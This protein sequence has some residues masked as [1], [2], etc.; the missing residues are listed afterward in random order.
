MNLVFEWV[1]VEI[2]NTVVWMKAIMR[3]L[4][5]I[6]KATWSFIV[7]L[8]QSISLSINWLNEYNNVLFKESRIC[9][10]IEIIQLNTLSL[11]DGFLMT[12]RC[13]CVKEESDIEHS[14]HLLYYFICHVLRMILSHSRVKRMIVPF[15]SPLFF[16]CIHEIIQYIHYDMIHNPS[17]NPLPVCICSS[18]RGGFICD[19][20]LLVCSIH[21]SQIE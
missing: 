8:K 6:V 17:I 10:R 16:D 20:T 9:F 18:M 14:T 7:H 12:I 3:F 15:S 19:S 21:D 4:G 11:L 5:L 13:L 1:M 2:L